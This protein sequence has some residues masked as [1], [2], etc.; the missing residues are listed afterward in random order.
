MNWI[1]IIIVCLAMAMVIGPIMI[2]QPSKRQRYL[3]R[4]RAKAA[5]HGLTVQ[6][7]KIKEDTVAVYEKP[8]PLTEKVKR[9]IEPWRLDRMSYVHDIHIADYWHLTSAT[10]VPVGV[11]SVLPAKLAELPEGVQAVEVTRLGVRCYWNERGG[12]QALQ[13]LANWLE[14]FTDLMIPYIPPPPTE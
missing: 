13:T 9:R 11:K 2:M 10:D 5:E 3:A 1:A 14:D 7:S 12:E 6:M 8:W 4:L